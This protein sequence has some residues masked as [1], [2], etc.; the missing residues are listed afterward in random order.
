MIYYKTININ[1]TKKANFKN[2]QKKSYLY[3]KGSFTKMR[4]IN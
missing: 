1:P 3:K 4:I 2:Y